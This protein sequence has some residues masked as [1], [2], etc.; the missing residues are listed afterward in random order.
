MYSKSEIQTL[1]LIGLDLDI[2]TEIL[3]NSLINVN[4]LAASVNGHLKQL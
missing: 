2:I 1:F 3:A 4:R